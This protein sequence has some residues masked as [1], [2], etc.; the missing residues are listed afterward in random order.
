MSAGI[1]SFK[2]QAI[3]RLKHFVDSPKFLPSLT[4]ARYSKPYSISNG[5]APKAHIEKHG[6]NIQINYKDRVHKRHQMHAQHRSSCVAV[7]EFL[8]QKMDVISKQCVYVVPMFNLRRTLYVK[9]IAKHT[10]LSDRT[11]T[12]VIGSLVRAGFLRVTYN[13]KLGNKAY[14][15][16]L[17]L[18]LFREL[19]L[20]LK[21]EMLVKQVRGLKEKRPNQ[22]KSASKKAS[23]TA[24]TQP[25]LSSAA[26]KP[27]RPPEP[28]Q[29]ANRDLA[30]GALD[31]IKA[32]L[33]RPLPA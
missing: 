6:R 15:Y 19:R 1:L 17:T 10:S 9:E 4:Y 28:T 12:R 7:I 3:E 13:E 23:S 22:G 8:I 21:F 11:V 29:P 33:K 16:F 27:Y 25:P 18:N 20:D 30:A 24:N 32:A 31:A 5:A 26:H 2:E 14:S